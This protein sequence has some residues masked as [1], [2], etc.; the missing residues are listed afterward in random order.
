MPIQHIIL[1]EQ[2]IRI[3]AFDTFVGNSE[4]LT[5]AVTSLDKALK[6][7][8]DSRNKSVWGYKE[9][10]DEEEENIQRFVSILSNGNDLKAHKYVGVIQTSKLRV[11]VLPKI[12]EPSDK[13]TLSENEII[14]RATN[15]LLYFLRYAYQLNLPQSSSALSKHHYSSDILEIIIYLFA[16]NTLLA[17]ERNIFKYYDIVEE[18]VNTIKGKLLLSEHIIQNV[19]RWKA[20]HHYCIYSQFQEN[21]LFNRIIKY[22]TS[23]LLHTTKS[24]INQQ[25]LRKILSLLPD[26]DYQLYS[27]IDCDKVVLNQ[28]QR[29]L[30][31][32]L[33][34]AKMILANSEMDF[35]EGR[36]ELFHFF[37]DMDSL[38]ERFVAGFMKYHLS[39][40]GLQVY[41]Q[42]S[43]LYLTEEH[44]FQLRHDIYIERENK[45]FL[46]IDTKNKP[47]DFSAIDKKSGISQSDLYQM[48]S[49]CIRRKVLNGLILYP[50]YI[51]D[52]ETGPKEYTIKDSLSDDI[53]K[54]KVAKLDIFV[55]SQTNKE[56]DAFIKDQLQGILYQ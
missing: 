23:I 31:P 9:N 17:L 13:E 7:S 50:K 43:D 42:K 6:E 39:N 52:V 15:N 36:I 45:P 34:Y 11:T 48:L 41:S 12:T 14:L 37:F 5:S 22:V 32:I 20:Y 55:N 21:N 8:W 27:S 30:R 47:A 26:V 40:D 35:V 19:V 25:L 2:Q 46:I 18:N 56:K 28:F 4:E 1:F 54:I 49:Y 24:D 3:N 33:N 53:I 10:N 16:E 29:D 44:I 38:F 51:S